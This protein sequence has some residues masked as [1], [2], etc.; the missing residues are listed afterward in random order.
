MEAGRTDNPV[1]IAL[2]RPGDH[3]RAE[4]YICWQCGSISHLRRN[5]RP[6]FPQ[7]QFTEGDD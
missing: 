7:V 1:C 6:E 4:R 2:E 5:C 3:V